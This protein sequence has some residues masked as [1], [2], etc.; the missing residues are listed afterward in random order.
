MSSL[1]T[2]LLTEAEA[3]PGTL[4][5]PLYEQRLCIRVRT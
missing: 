5:I 1:L 2:A 3:T 4:A